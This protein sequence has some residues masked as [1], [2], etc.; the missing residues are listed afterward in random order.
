MKKFLLDKINNY[1]PYLE[2]NYPIFLE[3]A[4][5][6]V[7]FN[8]SFHDNVMR[9]IEHCENISKKR[10]IHLIVDSSLNDRYTDSKILES[11]N[12][13]GNN[14]IIVSN[15]IQSS[16]IPNNL[17]SAQLP[18]N[19]QSALLLTSNTN[20]QNIN[21]TTEKT[22]NNITTNHNIDEHNESLKPATT[23]SLPKEEPA[24]LSKNEHLNE[25]M[26]IN[27]IPIR[28][29]FSEEDSSNSLLYTSDKIFLETIYTKKKSRNEFTSQDF[30]VIDG[31]MLNDSDLEGFLC[32]LEKNE[33]FHGKLLI[34]E[35]NVSDEV[36]FLA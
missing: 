11:N 2:N 33:Y 19:Q 10:D 31:M 3:N 21:Q 5:R 9:F 4:E 26:D 8:F 1:I 25:E 23:N 30:N 36:Y 27:G 35:Q 20:S 22:Q 32:A 6:L 34:V 7:E 15:N 18:N 24:A 29:D 17:Q 14:N 13:N 28:K 16:Q 12:I